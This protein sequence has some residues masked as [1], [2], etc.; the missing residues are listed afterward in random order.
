MTVLRVLSLE[1]QAAQVAGCLESHLHLWRERQEF[2]KY[3]MIVDYM[4]N[5]LQM[6]VDKSTILSILASSFTNDFSHLEAGTGEQHMM[7]P[8]TAM[9][10]H[11]C[12]PNISRCWNHFGSYNEEKNAVL[13]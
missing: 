9:L 11:S 10:N 12:F 5:T 1:P 6:A 13:T 8:L 3:T 7:L 4:K 2:S